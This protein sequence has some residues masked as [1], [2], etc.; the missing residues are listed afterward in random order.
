MKGRHCSIQGLTISWS[1]N[2]PTV[3]R[4]GGSFGS[5]PLLVSIS[6]VWGEIFSNAPSL[7]EKSKGLLLASPGNF[8]FVSSKIF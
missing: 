8:V 7:T 5:I 6:E 2:K 1:L 4:I 3:F